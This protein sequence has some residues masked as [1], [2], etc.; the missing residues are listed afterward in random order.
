LPNARG[1]CR[2]DFITYFEQTISNYYER[3][4]GTPF[5]RK[6]DSQIS[7]ITKMLFKIDHESLIISLKLIVSENLKI[8]QRSSRINSE[9]LPKLLFYL[10]NLKDPDIQEKQLCRLLENLVD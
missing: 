8:R 3:R 10:K 2:Q 1:N 5:I 4:L 6:V 7:S 9:N